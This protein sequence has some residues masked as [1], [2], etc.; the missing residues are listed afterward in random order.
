VSKQ[1]PAILGLM[2]F[3]GGVHADM[4]TLATDSPV[5]TP[6]VMNAG[7]TGGPMTVSAFNNVNPDPAANFMQAWLVTL[8][9]VPE[10]GATGTLTFAGPAT[11]PAAAPPNYIFASSNPLGILASNNGST[12]SANDFA[13]PTQVPTAPGAN[14]LQMTYLASSDASGLFS[15]NA[16]AG[17]INTSWTDNESPN[18]QTQF[19]VNVPNG[20]GQ[21][22]VGE[23][24]V[25]GA[26][27]PEPASAVLLVLGMGGVLAYRIRRSRSA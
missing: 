24:L 20:N 22:P 26:A 9:I 2:L 11:G 1:L 12:L 8:Q 23:V 6:L 27:V 17:D 5:G 10:A 3:T 7:A 16:L 18:P 13:D 4:I 25:I 15:I 19:F 14:L 21:I